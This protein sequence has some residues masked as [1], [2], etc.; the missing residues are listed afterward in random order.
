MRARLNGLL[1]ALLIGAC[2]VPSAEAK[3][4]RYASGPRAPEDSVLSVANTY[5]DP[6]VR[7]RGPRVPYTNLQLT[8]F[9][10][11]SA[12]ARALA[13]AP[14]DRGSHAVLA[15]TQNHPLNFVLEHA[16]LKEL[17]RRG[18]EVTVRRTPVPDDSVAAMYANPG[19]PLVEYTLGSAK[20][21]YLRLVGWL[22]G[23]VKIERQALV[24]GSVSMREPASSRV[25][26]T[27][28]LGQNFVDRFS[29]AQVSLVE[30]ARFPELKDTV[31]VR[32]LDK[33]VE[34]IIVVGVV[35][36]LVALFFQNRP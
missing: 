15:P 14:L 7:S 6:V 18:V 8:E 2:L 4:F 34:P 1:F 30:E 33:V 26:W 27:G 28:D 24:Q 22:P 20:I 11:D 19:D 13:T 12:A 32:N 16:F 35:G 36:G 9:V 29:R 5:L 25:L 31:P 3:K 21:T 10:A 23:R 17:A